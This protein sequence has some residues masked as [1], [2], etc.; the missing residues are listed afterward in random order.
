MAIPPPALVL[1]LVSLL[2]VSFTEAKL[3]DTLFNLM[4]GALGD[5]DDG[6]G[7]G[8][9]GGGG[10]ECWVTGGGDVDAVGGIMVVN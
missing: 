7:G 4:E 10:A 2:L 9:G 1:T 8:G 5:C 6:G 3:S